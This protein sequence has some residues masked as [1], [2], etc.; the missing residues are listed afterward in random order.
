MTRKSYVAA[1][2]DVLKPMGFTRE[3]QEWSRQIG[4][5]AE[6][7]DLQVSSIAGTT[8]NLWSYDT[9]TSDLLKKAIPWN[10]RGRPSSAFCA[11]LPT[12]RT[13]PMTRR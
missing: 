2:D 4:T 5:V 8:A 12:G 1:I 7:V 3:G 13:R 6:H 9:A 10:S 11:K